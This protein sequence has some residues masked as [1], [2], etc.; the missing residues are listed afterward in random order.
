MSR[1]QVRAALT[2]AQ[3]AS[4]PAAPTGMGALPVNP[5][6]NPGGLRRVQTEGYA[7]GGAVRD[8]DAGGMVRGPGGPRDDAIPARLSNGEFVVNARAVTA[9]GGGSNKVGLQKMNALQKLLEGKQR[10]T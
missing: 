6:T 3:A 7:M 4:A 5:V 10:V 1:D 9:L 2:A 8:Y